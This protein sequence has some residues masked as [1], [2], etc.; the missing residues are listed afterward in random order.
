ME[1]E[2]QRHRRTTMKELIVWEQA[3]HAYHLSLTFD[4]SACNSCILECITPFYSTGNRRNKDFVLKKKK[5]II[6]LKRCQWITWRL[7][8]REMNAS[9]LWM[10]NVLWSGLSVG[11]V[12]FLMAHY[13]DYYTTP[14]QDCDC[15]AGDSRKEA[16]RSSSLCFLPALLVFLRGGDSDF[17]DVTFWYLHF[18]RVF[19]FQRW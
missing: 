2:P 19:Q 12:C 13:W 4:I 11:Y 9:D 8:W 17:V 7:R 3:S 15:W 6:S 16:L 18:Y 1:L 14:H 5:D 10:I